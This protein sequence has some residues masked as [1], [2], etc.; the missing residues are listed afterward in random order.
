MFT[1]NLAG[2][3]AGSSHGLG[4]GHTHHLTPGVQHYNKSHS[5]L[6][7]YV[8]R[9]PRNGYNKCSPKSQL[10]FLKTFLGDFIYVS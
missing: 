3:G 9:R 1:A 8:A 5:R 6:N 2:S 7:L 4:G 10:G